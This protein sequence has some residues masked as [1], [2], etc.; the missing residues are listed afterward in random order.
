[1]P[2]YRD[3]LEQARRQIR[4]VD[5]PG[6]RDLIDR[7][8]AALDVREQDEI[9]QGALPAAVHIPRGYLELR[10]E[11]VLPDKDQPVV[12]YCAGGTRSVFAA[13]SLRE[14][15]YTEVVS[16]AGGFTAWSGEGAPWSVPRT[17]S[18]DQRRRYSRH[19]LIPEVGERGQQALLDA[20]VLLVGAGGLGSPAALYLAAAGVGTIGVVD[21]DT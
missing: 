9:E 17:L 10:V 20:S 15:G 5:V 1:M 4:E 12:V 18:A 6:A 19:L 7:G 11:D 3:I 21:A 8:A 2:T 13:K 14:L 16:L